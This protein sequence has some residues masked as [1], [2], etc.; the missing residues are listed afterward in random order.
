M[1]FMSFFLFWPHWAVI[2][3]REKG[4]PWAF[5][6]GDQGNAPT[7]LAT[8]GYTNNNAQNCAYMPVKAYLQ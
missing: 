7:R 6:A 1:F 8:D 2:E 4:M 3:N 5:G